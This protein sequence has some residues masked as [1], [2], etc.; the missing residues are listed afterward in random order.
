[1]TTTMTALSTVPIVDWDDFIVMF[2]GKNGWLRGEHVGMVG[3][4]NSGKTTLAYAILPIRQYV[5]VLSTK[6]ASASVDRFYKEQGY[7]LLREWPKNK[8]RAAEMPR[9]LLWPVQKTP[10]D[11]WTQASVM[12]DALAAIYQQGGWCVYWDELKYLVKRLGL[13]NVFD[14][15][16][17]Q[18]RELGIS[19]VAGTQRP[20][21]IPLELFDQSTHLFFWNERDDRNL[22]RISGISSLDTYLIRQTILDLERHEFLYINTRSAGML[23]STVKV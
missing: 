20:A 7:K 22:S 6:P 23:R 3:P 5:T 2:G 19:V 15:F 8:V 16:L 10:G 14:T 9:R 12:H 13:A 17:L 21:W 1:M 4:T 18:G 11:V